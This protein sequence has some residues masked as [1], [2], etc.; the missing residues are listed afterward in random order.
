MQIVEV[1]SKGLRGPD[2]LH[3]VLE[4]C[5][6]RTRPLEP[7]HALTLLGQIRR[8]Q[9]HQECLGNRPS[10]TPIEQRG[11]RAK[12]RSSVGIARSRLRGECVQADDA[13]DDLVALGLRDRLEQ[14][15]FQQ[16]IV[17]R[18]GTELEIRGGD[19]H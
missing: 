9:P 6:A 11:L 12:L 19:G 18:Q 7:A 5:L 17:P 1:R 14:Q 8:L 3:R 15:A 16:R 13:G 4:G 10:C 2:L